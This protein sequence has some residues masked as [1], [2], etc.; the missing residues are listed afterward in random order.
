MPNGFFIYAPTAEVVAGP[1]NS[2]WRAF[3]VMLDEEGT[4]GYVIQPT[5]NEVSTAHDPYPAAS[6]S[7]VDNDVIELSSDEEVDND[8]IELSS[9]EEVDDDIIELSSD[10]EVDDNI[11]ELPSQDEFDHAQM[12]FPTNN[13][14]NTVDGSDVIGENSVRA[15][16]SSSIIEYWYNRFCRD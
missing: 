16:D 4:R 15:H 13:N 6:S 7:E 8:V 9:D 14:L 12:E 10:E 2:T 3:V 1:L 5:T 11:I